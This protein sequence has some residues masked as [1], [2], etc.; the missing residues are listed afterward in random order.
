MKKVVLLGALA[1][2]GVAVLVWR[3]VQIDR[4]ERDLWAEITDPVS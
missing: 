2:T 1:L 4:D 3:E